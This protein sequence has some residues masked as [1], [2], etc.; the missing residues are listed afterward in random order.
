[1]D[2][3]TWNVLSF[4]FLSMFKSCVFRC[5][6]LDEVSTISEPNDFFA[7]CSES[8][9]RWKILLSISQIIIVNLIICIAFESMYIW[10]LLNA[11]N[12]PCWF[13]SNHIY[14]L[15]SHFPLFHFSVTISFVVLN[16]DT[17]CCCIRFRYLTGVRSAIHD[18]YCNDKNTNNNIT[19]SIRRAS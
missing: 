16:G 12:V 19:T 6:S 3:L 2:G 15:H 9:E 18:I 1:M 10:I 17:I 11:Q 8:A 7:K 5:N 4:I 13:S 14:S